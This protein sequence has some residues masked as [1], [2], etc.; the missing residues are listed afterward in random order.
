VRCPF[1]KGTFFIPGPRGAGN[2]SRVK[3]LAQLQRGGTAYCREIR[4]KKRKGR[5]KRIVFGDWV[6]IHRRR[7]TTPVVSKERRG[8]RCLPFVEREPAGQRLGK[9][10]E[11]NVARREK[12]TARSGKRCE[13]SKH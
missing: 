6:W 4:K 12:G 11:Q 10:G 3:R 8:G 1:G 9:K 7:K 2:E 5:L 13:I